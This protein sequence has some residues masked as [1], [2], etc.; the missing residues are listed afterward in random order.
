MAVELDYMEYANDAAAQAAYES[1]DAESYGADILNDGIASADSEWSASY[2]ASEAFDN[3]DSSTRWTSE[4]GV[5]PHWIKYD[6]GVS[7]TKIARQLR[8]KPEAAYPRDFLFQGSNN[9]SDWDTLL[10]ATAAESQTW[11]EWN[12]A[13]STAYRYY[14]IYI[15]SQSIG[16]VSIWEI[17]VKEVVVNLQCFSESSI[18]QQGS[19]SL[20][21]VAKQTG[22]LN[23][24]LTR[25][26]A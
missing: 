8:F 13:N 19:Y 11:Q 14:R 5:P 25:T 12:F 3:N 4:S 9:D 2:E 20:K 22:S 18:K 15:T 21:I 23:D 10:S 16:L 24:T 6:L 7:V 26:I 1:S 17:E